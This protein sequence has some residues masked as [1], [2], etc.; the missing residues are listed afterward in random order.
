ARQL[1]IVA[2]DGTPRAGARLFAALARERSTVAAAAEPRLAE[3][4]QGQ[5]RRWL[6]LLAQEALPPPY[7]DPERA[8][9]EPGAELGVADSQGRWSIVA[10]IARADD[11]VGWIVQHPAATPLF[12]P[13][14]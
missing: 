4:S 3:L 6:S 2:E 11:Q 7:S 9:P 5:W 1:H 13:D 10:D 12:I 8:L 14:P